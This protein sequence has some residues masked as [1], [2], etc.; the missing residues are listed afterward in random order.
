M[1]TIKRVQ[2]SLEINTTLELQ[3]ISHE[4][5]SDEGI[6][7]AIAFL[8]PNGLP[9]AQQ[10]ENNQ[11]LPSKSILCLYNDD[12]DTWNTRLQEMNNE[13]S[14]VLTS[15]DIF[16]DVDDEHG[17]LKT[18]LTTAVRRDFT[19]T[20]VPN[21]KLTLKVNDICLVTRNLNSLRLPSNSRVRII[22]IN[23]YSIIVKTM[24][25]EKRTVVIPRIKFK[26][27]L[28]YA[29][30]FSLIRVQFPLRLAYAITVHRSQSQS[31]DFVVLDLTKP[32][33]GHGQL[34]TAFSRLR[35]ADRLM[36][37]VDPTTQ[38]PEIG[39]DKFHINN[40]IYPQLIL[41]PEEE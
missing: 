14:H 18:M 28:K 19:N 39:E 13:Q 2:T 15:K 6:Q 41:Q 40:I 7:H 26:F 23:Q 22:R 33:F 16:A 35:Q 24:D 31:I 27:R 17:Y 5:N 4:S 3:S 12:V 29:S 8:Y 10:Y 25:T 20:D 32:A 1:T 34:Y 9:T 21:Y 38:P 37:I 11:E 36:V 30:S